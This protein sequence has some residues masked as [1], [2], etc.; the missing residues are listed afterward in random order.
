MFDTLNESKGYAY[1]RSIVCTEVE[2]IKRQD[3]KTPDLRAMLDGNPGFCEVKTI[4]M[5]QVEADRRDRVAHG[6]IR[7]FRVPF[8]V[9]PQMLQKVSA[10]LDTLSNN[11]TT[12][13]RI[14]PRGASCLPFWTSMIRFATIKRN[15]LQTSIRTCSPIP[16][17]EQISSCAPRAT[18]SSVAL[19][20]GQRPL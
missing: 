7:A 13:T 12:K 20:C 1:L 9:T 15:T 18:C 11:S 2:F 4:N 3:K 8:H 19:R 6:E 17:P 16:S 14:G 5:S 10:T